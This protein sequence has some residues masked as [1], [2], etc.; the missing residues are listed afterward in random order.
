MSMELTI[1]PVSTRVAYVLKKAGSLC[2]CCGV[3]L[4]GVCD[5]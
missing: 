2:S 5:V 3:D 4:C 1:T